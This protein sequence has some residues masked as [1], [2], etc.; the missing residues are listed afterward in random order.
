LFF[1]DDTEIYTYAFS[2]RGDVE[3]ENP[4]AGDKNFLRSNLASGMEE[5][6][7]KNFKYLDLLGLDQIKLFEIGKVFKNKG[8]ML[9]LSLGVK[10]PKSRKIN[11]D[12]EI[13]K[14]IQAMEE[15]LD[16]SV[17]DVSIVGGV[18][19]FD[20]ERVKKEL[21]P[22][23]EYPT[24]LWDS[25]KKNVT[26]KPISAFPFAVRDVAVFVPNEIKGDAVENLIKEKL[27][28][29]VVRFSMFDKFTKED[30][31]SYAFRLVFQANDRTLTEEEINAVMNP[32]YETL[33]AQSGFEIR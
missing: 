27:S 7:E 18:A 28:P 15:I 4:L 9:H 6:L 14:T 33:K 16:V 21:T 29:I 10:F 23:D 19:E 25:N 12:E 11:V 3:L 26:Y 13:A 20:L 17:G 8:E 32:I 24:G 5:S 22:A 31:T 2:N 30:K 1:Y